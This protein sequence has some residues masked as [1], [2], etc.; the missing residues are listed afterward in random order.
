MDAMKPRVSK[1][2]SRVFSF[3]PGYRGK[4]NVTCCKTCMT[5]ESDLADCSPR[6]REGG[7]LE[8]DVSRAVT[9]P[10]HD[11]WDNGAVSIFEL[12]ITVRCEYIII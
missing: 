11:L 9:A 4:T 8:K 6:T 5:G 3:L 12:I 7:V 10:L 1:W 2:Q